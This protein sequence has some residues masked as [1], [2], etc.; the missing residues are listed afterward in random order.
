MKIIYYVE[1]DNRD[2]KLLVEVEPMMDGSHCD[3][4]SILGISLLTTRK[5]FKLSEY[6]RLFKDLERVL[7]EDSYFLE[8]IE[9][10]WLEMKT[11]AEIDRALER[12]MLEAA[13]N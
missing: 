7:A 11:D 1:H 2:L 4:Y 12:I 13:Y 5:Q 3:D 10:E 6:S 9:Q 8:T